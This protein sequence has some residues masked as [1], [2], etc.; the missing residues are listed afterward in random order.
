[1]R[2]G[3][4]ASSSALAAGAANQVTLHGVAGNRT[5]DIWVLPNLVGVVDGCTDAHA[6][7]AIGFLKGE[8]WRANVLVEGAGGRAA[9]EL[10]EIRVVDV[11]E[12]A[13]DG[14][15]AHVEVVSVDIAEVVEIGAARVGKSEFDERGGGL[16]SDSSAFHSKVVEWRTAISS[17]TDELVILEA[18]ASPGPVPDSHRICWHN[19]HLI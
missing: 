11:D 8:F 18:A 16:S 7:G 19:H 15:E 14:S 5:K 6:V 4:G 12:G 10:A 2:V 13:G 3:V 17:R 1:M 9:V